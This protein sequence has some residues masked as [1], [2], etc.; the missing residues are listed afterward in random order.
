MNSADALRARAAKAREVAAGSGK[1]G[2]NLYLLELAT[3]YD[4]E[5]LAVERT[6]A[7]KAAAA[8]PG[9]RR[10]HGAAPQKPVQPGSLSGRR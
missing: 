10:E 7:G 4:E 1:R 2:P 9:N 5:A 3:R 6:H 8:L